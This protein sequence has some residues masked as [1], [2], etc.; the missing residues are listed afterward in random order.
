M[1]RRGHPSTGRHYLYVIRPVSEL[2]P[3]RFAD[4]VR[5]V[6]DGG[7][8]AYSVRGEGRPWIEAAPEI[9]MTAGLGY[10]AVADKQSWPLDVALLHG[11]LETQVGETRVANRGKPHLQGFLQNPTHTTGEYRACL[12]EGPMGVC[13]DYAHVDVCIDEAGHEGFSLEVECQAV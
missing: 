8:G 6:A 11:Q 1:I 4:F 13:L 12:G 7:H 5:S 3:G 10:H 2:F 9:A